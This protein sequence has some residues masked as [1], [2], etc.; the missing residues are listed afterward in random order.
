MC[1]LSSA[2]L[3]FKLI[4]NTAKLNL[5]FQYVNQIHR[6]ATRNANNLVIQRTNTQ[7]GAQNFFIRAL[8]EF[9]NIPVEKKKFVSI[10]LF[11]THLKE[12]L[13]LKHL[14]CDM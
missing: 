11:K 8:A 1:Q 12:H 3:V 10:N 5:P 2:Y 4:N 14:W 13:H 7:L 6:H 9:N